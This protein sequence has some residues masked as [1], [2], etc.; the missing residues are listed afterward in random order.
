MDDL[1]RQCVVDYRQYHLRDPNLDQAH[2]SGE[3]ER[4]R[5]KAR[6]G[7]GTL[8]GAFGNRHDCTEELFRSA[9]FSTEE[10]IRWVFEWRDQIIWPAEFDACRAVCTAESDGGYEAELTRLLKAWMWPFIK[11]AR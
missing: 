3:I 11:V 6:Q 8:T 7:W 9:D 5:L 1:L 2:E 10:V 4:L